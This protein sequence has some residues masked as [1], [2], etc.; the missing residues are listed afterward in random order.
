MQTLH[1]CEEVLS[2]HNEDD[3]EDSI[4]P[5]VISCISKFNEEVLLSMLDDLH[6]PVSISALSEPLKTINDLLH[7]RKVLILD[8][9]IIGLL[10]NM[11]MDSC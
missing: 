7:T 11:N 1:D 6:T 3:R 10:T 4:P 5:A 2:H 8:D 9:R